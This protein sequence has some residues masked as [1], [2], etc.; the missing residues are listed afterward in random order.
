VGR[1][2]TG[3]TGT[4]A[5]TTTLV[6]GAAGFIGAHLTARLLADGHH[7]LAVDN[8]RTSNPAT[9]TRLA[10]RDGRGRLEIM[11][12]DVTLPLFVEV[13]RIYHLA[14]PASPVHYQ[15][16]PVFT[17]KTSVVGAVNM[18]GL[19]RRLD[20]PILLTS[21][22]EVYG[23][24]AVSPQTEDYW[25][26]VNPV[27]PRSC[28][29]EGKRVAETLFYEYRAQYGTDTK[30][31][32]I[33]NTYG[34]GMAFDD[35]R[36]VSNFIVAALRGEPLPVFGDGTQTRSFAYVDDTVDALIRLANAPRDV[37]GPV[38]VGNPDTFT[39][40]ELADAVSFAVTGSRAPA[41]TTHHT[42]PVD[43][44]RHRTPDITRA[45]DLLG[46]RPTVDLPTGLGRTV[47]EFRARLATADPVRRVD[48]DA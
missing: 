29:D 43:D 32:R 22:S 16:D 30:I 26:H 35:G 18:L 1:V 21:T 5:T 37:A 28:Y 8:Y 36:V 33:F 41:V 25:G 15:R 45:H 7:V 2:V 6:T 38:N 47:E 39:M 4:G 13:D 31:A 11:R 17:V 44:P 10:A 19:A 20:V 23:D 3:A 12:H 46:W 9:L 40:N 48:V 27:G 34:P 14:C 42:L 24:P